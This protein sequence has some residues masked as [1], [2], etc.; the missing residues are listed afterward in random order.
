[1]CD[2]VLTGYNCTD[3]KA[4]SATIFKAILTALLRL[5][6]QAIASKVNLIRSVNIAD[7]GE[8][9]FFQAPSNRQRGHQKSA[10][11]HRRYPCCDRWKWGSPT[12]QHAARDDY[13]KGDRPSSADRISGARLP[14]RRVSWWRMISYSPLLPNRSI[15]K[16]ILT[17]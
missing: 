5:K 8:E 10:T 14:M 3:R 9:V 2:R 11:A 4:S 1:M 13:G 6:G 12:H 15:L 7:P 17:G 16:P